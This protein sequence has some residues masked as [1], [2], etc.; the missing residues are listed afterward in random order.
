MSLECDNTLLICAR[1]T[2]HVALCIY[3]TFHIVN[4]T[5]PAH[6]SGNWANPVAPLVVGDN[7]WSS[8]SVR[9]MRVWKCSTLLCKHAGLGTEARKVFNEMKTLTLMDV[10]LRTNVGVDIR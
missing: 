10:I 4:T 3:A 6:G 5:A 9:F 1:T 2:G 8:I 7:L